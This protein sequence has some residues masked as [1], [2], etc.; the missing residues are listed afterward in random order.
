MKLG[1]MEGTPEEIRD[2][3]QNNGLNI[4]DYLEKPDTPISRI[5]FVISAILIVASIVLLTLV[6]PTLK[7]IRTFLFVSGCGGGLWLAVIIPVSYTHLT[8]PTK[9]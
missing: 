5:W 2:F 9:A 6:Q 3:F 1:K 7:A 4:E 8:L